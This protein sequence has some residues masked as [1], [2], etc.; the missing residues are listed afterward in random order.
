MVIFGGNSGSPMV[1]MWGNVV[2]VVFAGN[3]RTNWGS[4]VPL[5]DVKELLK[6]Y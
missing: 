6:A 4:A 1:N 3:Q 5:K 2:G